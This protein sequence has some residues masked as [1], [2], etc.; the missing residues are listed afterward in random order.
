MKTLYYFFCITLL[1]SCANNDQNQVRQEAEN[2]ADSVLLI[3]NY[4][5]E[6]IGDWVANSIKIDI[7]SDS[8]TQVYVAKGEFE[9]KLNH[10]PM[11]T[12]FLPNNTYQIDYLN[13]QDSIFEKRRGVWNI[14]GDTLLLIEDDATYKY[15]IKMRHNHL[16]YQAQLDWDNDTEVDDTYTQIDQKVIKN[17]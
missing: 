5:K 10:K 17:D 2:F 13:L 1:F 15:A 11:Q 14:F 16:Q 4:P 7:K 6:I 3:A 8:A 12:T 9:T